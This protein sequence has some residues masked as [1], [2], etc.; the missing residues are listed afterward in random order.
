MMRDLNTLIGTAAK[1]YRLYSATAINERGQI[2][3]I[4]REESSDSF[5]AVL[6]TLSRDIPMV[7]PR[8][9]FRKSGTVQVS[10][11]PAVELLKTSRAR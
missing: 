3:A 1:R 10:K 4:A 2:T 6:L 11:V 9:V 5:H 7:K 8:P